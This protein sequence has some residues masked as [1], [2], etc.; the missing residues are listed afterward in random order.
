[1]LSRRNPLDSG[2]RFAHIG[3]VMTTITEVHKQDAVTDLLVRYW[4]VGK[5]LTEDE[6]EILLVALDEENRKLR[7]PIHRRALRRLADRGIT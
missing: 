1:M 3:D 6:K 4:G 5:Q 7:G 2:A